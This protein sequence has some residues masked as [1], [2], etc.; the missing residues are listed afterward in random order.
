MEYDGAIVD[1]DGTIYREYTPIPGSK[2]AIQS[3]RERGMSVIFLTNNPQRSP[4][5][6]AHRLESMGIPC[7]PGAVIT[8]GAVTTQYLA[9]HHP[10]DPIFLI[11]S[12]GLADQFDRAG[13]TLTDEPTEANIVVTSHDRSFDFDDLTAGLRAL[14]TAELFVGTDP[15]RVYPGPHGKPV[16]G[17]GAITGAVGG[18]ADRTPDIVF[19]K[20]SLETVEYVVER[21]DPRDG[22]WLV[23]GDSLKTDIAFGK[24]AGMDT[25]LV[26]SGLTDESDSLSPT[27]EFVVKTIGEILS[28]L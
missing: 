9:S 28:I 18:T 25:A 22:D 23:V 2:T 14:Q 8:A 4:D 5:A 11:G 13:L 17:S 15:D 16:P 10:N 21:L 26:R 1:L 24:R 7:E 19:G 6:I 3:L 27:P 20:P 12:D